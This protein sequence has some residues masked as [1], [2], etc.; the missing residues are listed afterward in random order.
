MSVYWFTSVCIALA[1]SATALATPPSFTPL[2]D[3]PGGTFQS[4]A[5]GVSADGSIVAGGSTSNC[6]A[7][8]YCNGEA[9]VWQSGTMT[10]LGFPP[11]SA[12]NPFSGIQAVSAD[13]S[14]LAGSASSDEGTNEPFRWANG[15]FTPL[16]RIPGYGNNAHLTTGISDDGT[17]IVGWGYSAD[18]DETQAWLWENDA[19]IGLGT[20]SGMPQSLSA[21]YGISGDGNVVVGASSGQ[22]FS[23][24][25]GDMTGL[26]TIPP[27]FPGPKVTVGSY[28]TATSTNGSVIVGASSAYDYDTEQSRLEAFRWSDA[29]MIGL[30]DLPGGEFHSS[31]SAV[32]AD[33]SIIAGIG[34]T[35][36][37]DEVFLWDA[38]NGMRELRGLLEND[39]GLDLTGWSLPYVRD[40]SADGSVI[41]GTGINPEGN[42]EAFLAVVPEPATIGLLL[43]G[44]LLGR[45]GRRRG[46]DW[47][48]S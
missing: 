12:P 30:G 29:M 8:G 17:R 46:L 40:I 34:S 42:Y 3:L 2:G 48:N 20:L 45:P 44:V 1:A 18:G 24:I 47:V 5:G 43:I 37:G 15:V 26:G 6:I 27:P 35:D 16:G 22:A 9:F 4:G 13:G 21:A 10:P 31:A 25:N 41:V 36:T 38:A 32:S 19:M 23:W 11:S 33:G 39:F 28:A 7:P 14:I